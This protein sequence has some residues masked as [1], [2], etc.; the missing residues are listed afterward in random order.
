MDVLLRINDLERRQ[1][2]DIAQAWFSSGSGQN[3]QRSLDFAKAADL[4]VLKSSRAEGDECVSGGHA[5]T[6]RSIYERCMDELQK[7]TVKALGADWRMKAYG[8]AETGFCVEGSDLDA[9]VVNPFCKEKCDG[10]LAVEA[11]RDKLQP[12]LN[13]HPSFWVVDEIYGAKVPILKLCFEKQLEV[14]VSYQNAKALRNTQFL[15]AYAM[16]DPM[17]KDLVVW[18]KSW[19]K[20]AGVCGAAHR[21]WADRNLS[22]YALTCMALYYLQVHPDL[23]MT[24]LPIKAFPLHGVREDAH[25]AS[26]DDVKWSPRSRVHARELI[27]GFLQF[28]KSEF[29]WGYEVVSV[30]RGRRSSSDHEAYSALSYGHKRRLHIEDPFEHSR[31]LHCVLTEER[32]EKL[33]QAMRD[34]VH[35]LN[36][37]NP[38]AVLRPL[39]VLPLDGPS[40]PYEAP[41]LPATDA[42]GR[43]TH[44]ECEEPANVSPSS[45]ALQATLLKGEL[46]VRVRRGPSWKW[47]D[48]DGGP[49]STGVTIP[50][51]TNGVGWVRVRWHS[52]QKN[53]YRVGAKGAYDL[54]VVDQATLLKGKLGVR[55][56]RGPSWKWGDQ[57]GG[58]GSTGVTIPGHTNGVGWVRVRWHSGQKNEYRV[59]AKGAYDLIVVDQADRS[60]CITGFRPALTT[61]TGGASGRCVDDQLG[62]DGRTTNEVLEQAAMLVGA[63]V[64]KSPS[65]FYGDSDDDDDDDDDWLGEHGLRSPASRRTQRRETQS[66]KRSCRR[67]NPRRTRSCRELRRQHQSGSAKTFS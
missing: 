56:R 64:V 48:Q 60:S 58:P 22:S 28:Y 65:E 41:S 26:V 50:G 11:L 51:H 59:G 2:Q 4:R 13:K 40:C 10:L 20:S 62:W 63:S 67:T 21:N 24:R 23:K 37:G 43:S 66:I 18:V 35:A 15:K 57:D 3:P 19:A 17:V 16:M 49:G 42:R 9:T 33:W 8:S 5:D 31:N 54:I 6:R 46:G 55:V 47:G 44:L 27:K 25:R 7:V 29:G 12:L 39:W 36:R 34:T 14:D 52:G 61:S 45:K 32:E 30:R 38:P 1:L 53:E